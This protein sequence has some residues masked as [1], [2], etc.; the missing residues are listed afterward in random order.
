MRLK[1]TLTQKYREQSIPFNYQYYISSFIY[2]TLSAANPV[3]SKWLHNQG[4]SS[5]HKKFKF[6]SFSFLD[7][8]K[9]EYLN[10][11]IKIISQDIYLTVTL[12]IN[13]IL[14]AFIAGLFAEQEMYIQNGGKKSYFIVKQCEMVPE[15]EYSEKMAFRTISPIVIKKGLGENGKLKYKFMSP[16]DE[17]YFE[18]FRMNLEEKYI[19][20]CTFTGQQI[21]EYKV[22]SLKLLNSAKPVLVSIK[23]ESGTEVNVKGYKFA[24]ELEGDPEFIKLGY[25]AGFGVNNSI[26]FGCVD[27]IKNKN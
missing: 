27:E 5:G 10:N 2:N 26:G 25:E 22:E 11:E 1:L 7:I 19:A 12:C 4:I 8:P 18:L 24:F 13:K 17:G 21:R 15:P 23:K 6:F 20:W 9:R 3:Y 14:E 16:E